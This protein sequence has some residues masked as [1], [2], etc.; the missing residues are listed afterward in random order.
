MQAEKEYM[1]HYSPLF[2]LYFK[3][4]LM[5]TLPMFDFGIF[6]PLLKLMGIYRVGDL[7][8]VFGKFSSFFSFL[9]FSF[10]ILHFLSFFF[11]LSFGGPW[12]LST[13][14]TQSQRHFCW[15]C[16]LLNPPMGEVD[17][18]YIWNI[19]SPHAAMVALN[20]KRSCFGSNTLTTFAYRFWPSTAI[21]IILARVRYCSN[22]ATKI[23]PPRLWVWS[24]PTRN[25]K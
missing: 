12:T 21:H 11:S 25:T 14:A 10:S 15:H 6:C 5:I 18:H 13:H 19:Y 16:W 1:G 24:V 20:M 9:F 7:V 22:M 4:C 2:L 8:W 23:H 17:H 3:K